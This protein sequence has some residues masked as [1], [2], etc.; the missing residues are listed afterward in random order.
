MLINLVFLKIIYMLQFPG[1]SAAFV[2]NDCEL[3]EF[4]PL[5][6]PVIIPVEVNGRKL[7][8]KLT[9]KTNNAVQWQLLVEF[10][11]GLTELFYLNSDLSSEWYASRKTNI[12]YAK[13]I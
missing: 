1:N 9:G 8:A 4:R 3:H 7:S 13:A 10:S 12:A 2:K 11:D 5:D 6:E